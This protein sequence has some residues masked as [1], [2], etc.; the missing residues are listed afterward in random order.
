MS[1]LN[2]YAKPGYKMG[3]FKYIGW[4]FRRHKYARQRARWGFCEKDVWDFDAYHSE[5][6]A[7]ALRFWADN[8][9]SHPYEV[10]EDDWKKLLKNIADCFAIWNQELPTP[11]YDAY[12]KAV[13]RIK[14][15]DGSVTVEVPDE[16]LRAWR[17][18]EK[19][20]YE[21]KKVKLKE[22]F[23]MLYQFYPNMWD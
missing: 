23:D 15:E 21:Y 10:S 14:N 12:R 17:E 5:L 18:E 9:N 22:G 16:L 1:M 8:T 11:A 19:A 7:A 6:V 4:M 20:N 2:L 13:K 3:F